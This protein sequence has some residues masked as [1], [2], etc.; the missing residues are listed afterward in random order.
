MAVALLA[1]MIA[2]DPVSAASEV[3]SIRAGAVGIQ[4]MALSGYGYLGPA[5]PGI[6]VKAHFSDRGAVL[7]TTALSLDSYTGHDPRSV[8][9]HQGHQ[10]SYAV[11]VA[12]EFLEYV[13]PRGPVTVFLGLGPFWRRSHYL[14]DG[15]DYY[16]APD[17]TVHTAYGI[18]ERNYWTVGGT[19]TVGFEWFFKR[20]LSMVGRVGASFSFGESHEN[21]FSASDTSDP[22][23]FDRRAIDYTNAFASSSSATLGLAVYF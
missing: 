17:S 7:L 19:G 3:N 15:T 23:T 10:R 9:G 21:Y 1:G 5:Q 14:S 2:P 22:S 11:S 4:F 6:A 18:S 16:T 20:K 13:D 12:A 8:Q